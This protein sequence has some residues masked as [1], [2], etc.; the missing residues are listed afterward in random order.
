MHMGRAGHSYPSSLETAEISMWCLGV[1]DA[2]SRKQP[3]G[4]FLK[5]IYSM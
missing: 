5:S 1:H 4:L 2:N 3:M